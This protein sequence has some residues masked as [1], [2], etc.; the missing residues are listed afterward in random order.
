[1]QKKAWS[2]RPSQL[3]PLLRGPV[4]MLTLSLLPLSAFQQLVCCIQ[5]HRSA[6]DPHVHQMNL[7]TQ[8]CWNCSA[9]ID[10]LMLTNCGK[11]KSFTTACQNVNVALCW[12]WQ[13]F[14]RC[15]S[16]L[17]TDYWVWCVWLHINLLCCTTLAVMPLVIGNPTGC[18]DWTTKQI[19][20]RDPEGE[21]KPHFV[22]QERILNSTYVNYIFQ[23]RVLKLYE[24]YSSRYTHS[25]NQP[26]DAA[27]VLCR[28]INDEQSSGLCVFFWLTAA[29]WNTPAEFITF[30]TPLTTSQ[31]CNVSC[32]LVCVGGVC[33]CPVF[34]SWLQHRTTTLGW[35]LLQS[36]PPSKR[37]ATEVRQ[38][39]EDKV[40]GKEW[41][42]KINGEK[43]SHFTV[44]ANP[45][46][47]SELGARK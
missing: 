4:L 37:K 1:M 41:R 36:K 44:K 47:I 9:D 20:Q 22:L 6:L 7:V 14:N 19:I 21:K 8:Y 17:P 24:L 40:I 25:M 43:S 13:T 10:S 2:I 46:D 11:A 30:Y 34:V 18:Y 33:K 16:L 12:R 35:I 31:P 32:L 3:L 45:E 38:T 28:L 42:G 23:N 26:A 29:K 39:K 15:V 5:P 27:A